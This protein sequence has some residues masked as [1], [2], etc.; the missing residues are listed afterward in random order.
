MKHDPAYYK[1]VYNWDTVARHYVERSD[2]EVEA[3]ETFGELPALPVANDNRRGPCISTLNG[4]FFP[5]DP[6]PEDVDIVHIAHSLGMLCRYTGACRRFYS[7]GE[8]SVHIALW[9]LPKFGPTIALS[10]LLHDAPETL[11][12]FGDN[13]R[14]SKVKAPII[15]QTEDAI[16]RVALSR[17]FDLPAPLPREVHEADS[18]IIADEMQQNMH[19]VDPSYNNPLGVKLQY[20]FPDVAK[21]YFL[22]TFRKIQLMRQEERRA[23]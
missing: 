12:G 6:K 18:R 7:V 1:P 15:K 13:A 17:A 9:L 16:Y 2:D 8:H 10:G 22:D 19:E 11:S 3:M 21:I 23:A 5:F 20:W 4:R 14:P